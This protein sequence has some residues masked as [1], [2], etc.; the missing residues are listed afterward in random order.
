MK[1]ITVTERRFRLFQCNCSFGVH[2]GSRA[3]ARAGVTVDWN[4]HYGA[5]VHRE[6][7]AAN[8]FRTM[9]QYY[10]RERGRRLDWNFSWRPPLTSQLIWNR[11]P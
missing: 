9:M 10:M 11:L 2:I 6:V 5:V 4:G 8:A 7:S 1:D 3:R